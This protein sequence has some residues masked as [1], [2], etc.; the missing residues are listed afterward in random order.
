MISSSSDSLNNNIYSS[1][2]KKYMGETGIT[3]PPQAKT[4]YQKV[5]IMGKEFDPMQPAA[6]LKS[7]P[8]I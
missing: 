3:I 8:A 1:V 5:S 6:Y 7:F 4:G 2:A